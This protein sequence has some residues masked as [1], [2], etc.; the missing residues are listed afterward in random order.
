MLK[1]PFVHKKAQENFERRIHRRVIKVFDADRAVLDL[2]LRYL[3]KHGLGGVGMRAQ[4]F[5]W[6]EPGQV[7]R[8]LAE[9]EAKMGGMPAD[10]IRAKAE[11]LAQDLTGQGEEAQGPQPEADAEKSAA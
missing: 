9:L 2:W 4:V 1:S 3:K 7:G 6:V 8:E 11:G 5:E 10:E